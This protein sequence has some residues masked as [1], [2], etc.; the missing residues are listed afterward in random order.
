MVAR[1][2][3]LNGDF[4]VKRVIGLPG[5]FIVLA[6]GGGVLV[7]DARLCE[8]Y[9]VGAAHGGSRPSAWTCDDGEYF[10]MGD[11]R[12]DSMDS[13]RY[14]PVHHSAIIGRVWLRW[15]GWRNLSYRK[16]RRR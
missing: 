7:D 15:P 11:N 14:G 1:S 3:A 5:E 16:N 12:A 4:W 2:P 9:R 8:P 10:L 6:D 13:R